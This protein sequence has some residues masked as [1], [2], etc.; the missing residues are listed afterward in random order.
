MPMPQP[1]ARAFGMF[2]ALTHGELQRL[3]NAPGLERYRPEAIMAQPPEGPCVPALCYNLQ[4][5]PGPGER[6]PEYALRLQAVL[7][8][9]GFPREYVESVS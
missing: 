9:L 7:G 5:A 4:E 1:G 2:M 3:Y 8:S 6:N